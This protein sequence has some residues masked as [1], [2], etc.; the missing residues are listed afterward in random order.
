LYNYKTS[1][2]TLLVKDSS[3]NIIKDDKGNQ[4]TETKDIQVP[5]KLKEITEAALNGKSGV[6]EY[7][8][9]SGN[10]V[11]SA[12]STIKL[13]GNSSNWAVVTVQKK[14]DAMAFVRDY[15]TKNVLLALGLILAVVLV[16][17]FVSNGI[18]KPIIKVVQL[19]EKAS[20][21]DLTVNS[22]Y[23]SRN[24]IGRLSVSFSNMMVN[25]KDLMVQID[26]LGKDVFTS[27]K[28]LSITTEQTAASIEDVSRAITEIADGASE[29]AIYAEEG[30]NVA[31]K[32][33]GEIE[34]WLPEIRQ[35]GARSACSSSRTLTR[36]NIAVSTS[37]SL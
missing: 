10:V 20:N 19:M 21:G 30:V 26:E 17:Y 33:S 7:M 13:P 14:S 37:S 36:R 35:I 3:G 8:D 6:A 11:I 28:T 34:S 32:L 23:I 24:E 9:E 27:S 5:S 16:T 4:L 12:Y 29:Q 18:T 1:T 31:V 2:K 22:N 15:Q 25:I